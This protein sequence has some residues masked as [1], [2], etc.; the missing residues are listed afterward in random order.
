MQFR[1]RST[2]GEALI[3]ITVAAGFFYSL[4]EGNASLE[5]GWLASAFLFGIVLFYFALL[6]VRMLFFWMTGGDHVAGWEERHLTQS[7]KRTAI[8]V[9]KKK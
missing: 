8:V 5:D 7:E 9:P 3:V 4:N 6:F 2:I 1:S